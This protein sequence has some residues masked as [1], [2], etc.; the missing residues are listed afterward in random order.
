MQT[1]DGRTGIRGD[2]DLRPFLLRFRWYIID[3]RLVIDRT[4]G[5]ICLVLVSGVEIVRPMSKTRIA[6]NGAAGRMGKRIVALGMADDEIEV[7]AALEFS[8]HAD[9][10]KDAGLIAGAEQLDVLVSDHLECEVDAVIDFSVPASSQNILETC[11]AANLPLVVATTGLTAEQQQQIHE[12]ARTIPIVWAPNMS[13]AVNLTMNLAVTAARALKDYSGGVDVE[14]IER[15]HRFKEDA[16]SGTALKFGEQIARE[17]GQTRHTHGR[18]GQTGQR[19]ADEI[20]YHALRVADNPGEHTIIFGLMGET[21]EVTVRATNRD[22]Y[23][24]GALQAAKFIAR[25][26]PGL[27]GMNDVLGLP[28]VD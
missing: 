11:L 24:L 10:G 22:A 28:V 21:V 1:I 25:Q 2:S 17:M 19:P 3:D 16:P 7:S 23:A 4:Y 5:G 13:L 14:I 26:N 15:H 8:Q 20:G 6:M 18:Q 9:I 27:Y 12:S